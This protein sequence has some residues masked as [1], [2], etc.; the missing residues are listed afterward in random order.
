MATGRHT[1]HDDGACS[2]DGKL[3]V[4]FVMYSFI[5]LFSSRTATQL[6]AQSEQTAPGSPTQAEAA[7]SLDCSE[8]GPGLCSVIASKS[9]APIYR[10]QVR[11][12][13]L[14]KAPTKRT[15]NF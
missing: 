11:R 3:V 6:S 4:A 12:A 5:F 10:P 14:K 15:P 9:Q 8:T 1:S 7:S 13:A 2:S